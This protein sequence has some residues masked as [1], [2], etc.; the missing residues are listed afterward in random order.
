MRRVIQKDPK[1]EFYRNASPTVAVRENSIEF[2]FDTDGENYCVVNISRTN[3]SVILLARI[4]DSDFAD[5]LQ[6]KLI[7]LEDWEE[8]APVLTKML[9][10]KTPYN[11]ATISNA[12]GRK[13]SGILRRI[14]GRQKGEVLDMI[15]DKVIRKEA[16][17]V[18]Q[19]ALLLYAELQRSKHP[20]LHSLASHFSD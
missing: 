12:D 6:N 17:I 18:A 5:I 8:D 4:G 2:I 9:T 7:T 19:A 16:Y 15:G 3:D 11:I 13:F 10:G 20:E 14:F 1:A